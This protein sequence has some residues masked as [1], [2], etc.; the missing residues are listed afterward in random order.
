M[1]TRSCEWQFRAQHKLVLWTGTAP[2]DTYSHAAL[3]RKSTH[4]WV[5]ERTEVGKRS[6]LDTTH[7]IVFPKHTRYI[8]VRWC[9]SEQGGVEVWASLI[10]CATQGLGV[11]WS[12]DSLNGTSSSGTP[13][14]ALGSSH[15]CVWYSPLEVWFCLLSTLWPNPFTSPVLQLQV[16]IVLK[17][18]NI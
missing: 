4:G 12:R 15:D 14:L 7:H 6:S 16:I 3:K 5:A 17:H 18:K 2:V 11:W 1:Q 9:P 10:P 13:R 8:R